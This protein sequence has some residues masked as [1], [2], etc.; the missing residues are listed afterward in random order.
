MLV[1]EQKENDLMLLM[2]LRKCEI[3]VDL[4]GGDPVGVPGDIFYENSIAAGDAF[5]ENGGEVFTAVCTGGSSW[6]RR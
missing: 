2:L 1:I 6:V 4:V 5:L 3:A